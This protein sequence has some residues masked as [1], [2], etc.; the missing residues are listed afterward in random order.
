M[1]YTFSPNWY[2]PQCLHFEGDSLYY[3]SN[4]LLYRYDLQHKR[5]THEVCFRQ[6]ALEHRL[7]HRDIKISAIAS[8]QQSLLVG[9]SQPFLA[10][11]S[12]DSLAL[13]RL[14]PLDLLDS[15][16]YIYPYREG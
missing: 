11:L 15:V 3:C 7:N 12:K 10:L 5:V 14:V 4:Y 6:I 8:N 2:R 16:E 9:L 13:D 1:I